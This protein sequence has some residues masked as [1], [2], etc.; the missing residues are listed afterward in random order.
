[1]ARKVTRR[2]GKSRKQN[3]ISFSGQNLELQT[4]DQYHKD[5]ESSLRMYFSWENAV[6]QPRFFGY[7]MEELEIEFEAT[8]A[9]LEKNSSMSVLAAL[10]AIFRID[11]LQRNY[12]RRRDV[13]PKSL[14]AVHATRGERASLEDEIFP[15]W[16]SCKPEY[17][18]VISEL[19]GAFKYRHWLASIPNRCN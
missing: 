10:E 9:E 17:A 15:V 13:L 6:T 1:M 14:R 8:L 4:I 18:R 5:F 7:T 19:V 12:N 11:Y 16:R 3:R 2:S